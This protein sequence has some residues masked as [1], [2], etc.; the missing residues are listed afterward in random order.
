MTAT[1]LKLG[2][3]SLQDRVH[4]EQDHHEITAVYR[5]LITQAC[6]MQDIN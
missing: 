4:I 6:A 5:A 1:S 3:K 2:L